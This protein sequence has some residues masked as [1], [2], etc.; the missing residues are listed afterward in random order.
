[1]L[2]DCCFDGELAVFSTLPLSC[3]GT[4]PVVVAEVAWTD[5]M[6]FV[7]G[8]GACPIILC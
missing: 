2:S 7:D 1:M 3:V 8:V 6:P 5:G 4:E